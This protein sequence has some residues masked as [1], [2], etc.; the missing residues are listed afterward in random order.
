VA[1][2]KSGARKAPAKK[3]APAAKRAGSAAQRRQA[4]RESRAIRRRLLMIPVLLV[5]AAGVIFFATRSSPSVTDHLVT[6]AGGC[7]ADTKHDG[8]ASNQGAHVRNP[9]YE[10]DPP[11]GGPH[12]P[13]PAP[14]GFYVDGEV[15]TDGQLVHAMEHGFVVLWVKPDLPDEK[16][17]QVEALS[18]QFGRE[19]IVVQRPSLAGEV[20]VTAWHQRLLCAELVPDKVATFTRA[21]KDQ[22]PEKG[23][24]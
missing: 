2:N 6:G 12:F 18:D 20:A 7:K 14:P 22:G 5:V 13:Q 3:K 16:M 24:L 21:Y 11:A 19:L 8:D 9:T 1:T 17:K 15:P 10:V 4:D 23:F